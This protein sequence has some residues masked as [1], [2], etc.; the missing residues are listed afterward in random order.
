MPPTW[1]DVRNDF[2][3]V[4]SPLH[5]AAMMVSSHH[6]VVR[7]AVERYRYQFDRQPWV[8]L[9]SNLHAKEGAACAAVNRYFGVP[10]ENVALID[11][12]TLGLV[13]LFEGV[14][15]EADQEILT[16]PHEFHGALHSIAAR[17]SPGGPSMRQ[18]DPFPNPSNISADA[19]VQT[20]EHEIR[21]NTRVLAL[22]WVYSN[23]G[24]KLPI[25]R[26]AAVVQQ[27][28]ARPERADPAKRLLFCV[29]G[30]VGL[31]VE[32]DMFDALGCDVFVGG[33]HKFVYGPRGTGIWCATPFAWTQC[34]AIAPTSSKGTPGPLR[35]PGGIHSYEQ[36]WA[37]TE[38]FDYLLTI[39]KDRIRDRTHDLA[40]RFKNGLAAM[41]GRITTITPNDRD[42]SSAIVCF[43]VQNQ[44]PGAFVG[45]LETRGILATVAPADTVG[46]RTVSHA[47]IG[48]SIF[49]LEE[50]VD[51]C[52]NVIDDLSRQQ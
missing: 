17:C 16:T 9:K 52:L 39:G 19:V 21:D 41:G 27:V 33:C 15:I 42:L 8:A 20:V 24:V 43:D 34:G 30:V 4:P 12:T 35:S 1:Q 5:F 46:G 6:R 38:A 32:P 26:I 50:D 31:G 13:L 22:S 3:L 28:N 40:V 49:H 18:I 44:T 51:R 11:G 29:D 36:R 10:A 23:S 14:K 37:L 25:A 7:E 45:A 47:R 2:D 48:L